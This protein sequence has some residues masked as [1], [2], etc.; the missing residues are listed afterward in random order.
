VCDIHEKDREALE[1]S[2]N[3]SRETAAK[4]MDI[5]GRFACKITNKND[6][7][8]TDQLAL[9]NNMRHLPSSNTNKRK[10][11]GK[12]KGK[13]RAK[14]NAAADD[15]DDD[16]YEDHRDWLGDVPRDN[17][18]YCSKAPSP[19]DIAK[20][21]AAVLFCRAKDAYQEGLIIPDPYVKDGSVTIKLT[22]PCVLAN[23]VKPGK[24]INVAIFTRV[25][26]PSGDTYPYG[27]SYVGTKLAA[28][29]RGAKPSSKVS[30]KDRLAARSDPTNDDSDDENINDS[31]YESD[32][33][34]VGHATSAG[35]D[36][37]T[38]GNESDGDDDSS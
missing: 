14:G 15:D 28:A 36:S 32:T 7:D 35:P 25:G 4:A 31:D 1:K 8:I 23:W 2:K 38:A 19:A 21:K 10:R 30:E 3:L 13:G 26:D 5:A 29:A 18:D 34:S 33:Q 9:A 20:G 16:D 12:G 24:F 6:V 37:D 22:N 27:L 11:K 17:R